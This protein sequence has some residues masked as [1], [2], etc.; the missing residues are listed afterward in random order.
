M[1]ECDVFLELLEEAGVETLDLRPWFESHGERYGDWFFRTDHH[2]R[3]EAAFAA[4]GVLAEELEGRYGFSFDPALTDEANYSKTVYEDFF[5]GSQG[6]RTG[7]LYAGVDDF[8]VYTPKFDTDL[9]YTCPF[10]DME[11][12][13]P[14]EASVCF[15]ERVAGRDWFN[16]NPYTYYAGGDYPLARIVNHNNP[17]GPKLLLIR[18]SFA[19]ALTPFLALGCSEVV[20]VDLRYFS[21]DLLETIRAEEPGLV[22]NLYAVGTVSNTGMFYRPGGEEGAP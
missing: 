11:R 16:G 10:Y 21:G 7:S 5:L 19:C 12:T 4:W 1:E 14:F 20:T 18:D 8:T 6:K 2:G 22:L 17:D 9:T 3:P 13:G 15:P